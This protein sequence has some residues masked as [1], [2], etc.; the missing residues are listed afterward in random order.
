MRRPTG[1]ERRCHQGGRD[2]AA[3]H[4]AAVLLLAL[5]AAAVWAC[6]MLARV[7]VDE[8]GADANPAD[9]SAAGANAVTL[10][11]LA[12]SQTVRDEW[13]TGAWSVTLEDLGREWGDASGAHPANGKNTPL[14]ADTTYGRGAGMVDLVTYDRATNIAIRHY[15][16]IEP[17]GSVRW[18]AAETVLDEGGRPVT[19]PRG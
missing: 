10:E 15:G 7:T 13:E 16:Q 12:L 17:D 4:G 11:D 8:V 14:S 2:E 18:Y 9:G 5:L 1:D 3:G 19:V 6:A